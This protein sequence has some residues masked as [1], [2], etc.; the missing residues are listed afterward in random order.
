M[1][2][3]IHDAWDLNR[4]LGLEGETSSKQEA[5]WQTPGCWS[6]VE[7]VGSIAV[8]ATVTGNAVGCGFN[9]YTP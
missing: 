4:S 5:P 7:T 9:A 6:V 1:R 2:H 8:H 3:A